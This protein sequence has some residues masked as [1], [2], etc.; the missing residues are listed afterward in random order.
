MEKRPRT[1]ESASVDAGLPDEDVPVT[2][3]T[4]QPRLPAHSQPLASPS[5]SVSTMWTKI[6]LLWLPLSQLILSMVFLSIL[7]WIFHDM[8]LAEDPSPG[9]LLSAT[10]ANILLSILTQL[11]GMQIHLLYSELFNFLRWQLASRP[12]G[13]SASI[14]FALSSATGPVATFVFTIA[15]KCKSWGVLRYD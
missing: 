10:T 9:L 4:V 13:V 11:F 5:L 1:D 3:P 12:R 6:K 8:M 2:E 15:D 7:G 14:F